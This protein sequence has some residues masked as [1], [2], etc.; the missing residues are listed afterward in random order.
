MNVQMGR[1]A[2]NFG[3]IMGLVFSIN[4]LI[5]TIKSLVFLQYIFIVAIIYLAYRFV[6]HFRD[7][8]NEGEISYG[9]AFLYILQLFMYASMIS[10]VVRYLFYSYIKPDFLQNQLNETLA[11]LQGTPMANIITGD[12]YQQ[13]VELMTP[14]NMALQ[15]IWLNLLLGVLLGL[16]LAAVVKKNKSIFDNTD[17][18]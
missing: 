13:T 4:F 6:I 10:A 8:V 17:V 1:H 14:L 7:N 18:E 12:I 2:M 9:Y 11:A 5:T 16:I 15:A 3:A